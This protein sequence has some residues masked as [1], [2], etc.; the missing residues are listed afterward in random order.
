MGF[1]DGI[2]AALQ[3]MSPLERRRAV[4]ALRELIYEDAYEQSRASTS[5]KVLC[6]HCGSER[7][8][9]K[10][11]DADGSQ[12][13]LCKGCGRTFRDEPDTIITRSKLKPAVW[14]RYLRVLRRLPAAARVREALRRVAAHVMAHA[15]AAHREHQ[16]PPARVPCEGRRSRA[17]R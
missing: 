17:A 14:M 9:R 7:V 4:A 2:R 6:P 12:R 16:G 13:W 11:H 5:D 8:V 10:G 1:L 3:A 15:H